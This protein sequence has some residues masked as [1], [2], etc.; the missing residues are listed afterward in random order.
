LLPLAAL[1]LALSP[2]RAPA[3]KPPVCPGG[4]FEV[5]ATAGPLVPG[6]AV[7]DLLVVGDDGAVSVAS[8]CP[9]I[10]GKLRATR[11]GTRIAAKWTRKRGLCAGL[12]KKS[13]LRGRFDA[14]CETLAATFAT[15]GRKLEF[16]ATRAGV[17][18]D[19][20]VP[21]SIRG[22]GL[23]VG[24]ATGAEM[25]AADPTWADAFAA[26][27]AS[28]DTVEVATSTPLPGSALD[29]HATA[30]TAPGAGWAQRVA[31]LVA[32]IAANPSSGYAAEERTLGGRSV[33]K[34]TVPADAL[35][36][37]SH[38][39]VDGDTLLL[40]ASDDEALVDE[41]LAELPAAGGAALAAA[42][43]GGPRGGD[44]PM[45]GGT[46]LVVRLLRP[47]DSRVC[48]AEPYGRVTLDVM[49]IDGFYQAP[50][51]AFFVVN[52]ARIGETRAILAYGGVG[53]FQ[54]KAVR[55]DV[56]EDL[57]LQGVAP[58]GGQGF[59][60]LSFPV[61][62]CLNG[63]WQDGDRQVQVTQLFDHLVANVVSGT[64]CDEEGGVDFSGDMITP[65]RFEGSDLKVCN[66]EECAE[67]GLLEP[68]VRVDYRALIAFDGNSAEISWEST[69]FDLVY[70][71][72]G[73]L[74]GC[75]PDG[76]VQARTFSIQRL[77]F[78]PGLP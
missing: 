14:S 39:A 58:P 60:Y 13:R 55:F 2:E 66:P 52:S 44:P 69:Q 35:Y 72:G 27:G 33:W 12:P 78:G 77:Q 61:R 63:T 11:K 70:D 3:A 19:G 22:E 36:P 48:V 6:G 21:A 71:D 46:F 53:T 45:P 49:A 31:D 51:P 38:Y 68:S 28:A 4:V 8:G 25:L 32:G 17:V 15:R 43:A 23:R 54:Y 42:A 76:D 1:A 26:L 5:D 9:E 24:R 40:L 16:T 37:A 56:R 34:V 57:Q 30:W 41:V 64:I 67:A 50:V 75:P 47:V 74:V 65:D 59:A 62:H 29:L 20:H 18:L 10:A 73:Q 7:P